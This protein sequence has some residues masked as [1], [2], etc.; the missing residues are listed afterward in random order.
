MDGTLTPAR[1]PAPETV[2]KSL[3]KLA[4]Y[5]KI[6]IVT[7]S[8]FDYLTQQCSSLWDKI[9]T[10]SPSDIFLLPCNGTKLYT[11]G[12][13]NWILQEDSNMRNEVTDEKFNELMKI[14]ITTQFGFS[15]GEHNLP[16]TGH[17]ISYRGSMIN[18]CP[19]GRNANDDQRKAFVKWDKTHNVRAGILEE[20]QKATDNIFS[21]GKVQLAL[22]GNT[23]IDIYPEGW[24]KT[25]ALKYFPE[26]QCWFVGD[27]CG[28][29]GNDRHIYE[30]LAKEGRGFETTGPENTVEIINQIIKKLQ[31]Q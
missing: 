18:W 9:T 28:P 19:I 24:D 7:G 25:Y 10:I 8:D 4:K 6:G 2:G 26:Y 22:G 20:L 1:M 14:L 13:N 17:F 5:A 27:R 21:P 30:L 29:T 15:C 12:G 3:S 23:S 11:W 16:L 31:P